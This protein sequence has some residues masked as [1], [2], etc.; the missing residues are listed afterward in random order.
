MRQRSV[1]P[2][3]GRR[4]HSRGSPRREVSTAIRTPP[5]RRPSCRA[6]SKRSRAVACSP[7]RPR[8][9]RR[10]WLRVRFQPM[11]LRWQSSPHRSGSISAACKV[12]ASCRASAAGPPASIP[13][14]LPQPV[15]GKTG[16]GPRATSPGRGGI[17]RGRADAELTYGG[18]SLPAERFKAQALPPGYVRSPDD[19]APIVNLPGAPNVAP[20]ASGRAAARAYAEDAGQ[21]AWRRTLA[22]RHQRAVKQYFQP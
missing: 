12:W 11:P 15:R 16:R 17:N 5:R 2:R 1:M 7:A 10:C 19:W 18:E 22:P 13:P 6:R 21:A 3:R 8:I 20:E 4:R 9:S 14:S